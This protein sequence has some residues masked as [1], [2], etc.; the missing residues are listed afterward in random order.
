MR[1]AISDTKKLKSHDEHS[2]VLVEEELSPGNRLER[3]K[4]E[5]SYE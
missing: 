4:D 2:K 3:P 5:V 1:T